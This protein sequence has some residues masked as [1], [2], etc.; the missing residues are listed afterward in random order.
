MWQCGVEGEIR[1]VSINLTSLSPPRIFRMRWARPTS[2]DL[3]ISVS[4]H[5]IT[6]YHSPTYATTMYCTVDTMCCICV[7]VSLVDYLC[8]VSSQCSAC[9][10]R[11]S[12]PS[13]ARPSA[14]PLSLGDMASP[15]GTLFPLS[16]I[17]TPPARPFRNPALALKRG[18]GSKFLPPVFWALSTL[19]GRGMP[20]RVICRPQSTFFRR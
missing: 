7:C 12:W 11:R 4:R 8:S 15:P 9:F 19:R 13:R 17:V 18:F 2:L 16:L 6:S 14:R 5:F 3:D 20:R 10:S 1:G